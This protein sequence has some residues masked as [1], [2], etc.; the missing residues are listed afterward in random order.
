LEVARE[1]TDRRSVT[2]FRHYYPDMIRVL[3]MVAGV[4][5]VAGLTGGV[6]A[7][8]AGAEP[9]PP[10]GFTISPPEIVV[11]EGISVVTTIVQ[12]DV[13][14]VPPA[15]PTQTVACIQLQGGDTGSTCAQSRPQT[16]V[17]QVYVPYQPGATYIATGRG[18]PSW[19]GQ[20]DVAPEW[21]ILGPV[22]ATL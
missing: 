7:P 14:V 17:A 10:C 8:T 2:K 3:S 19:I 12:P 22:T 11:N 9:P 5:M 16:G 20:A 18:V 6:G 13:C 1:V 15:G 4:T 21:Q